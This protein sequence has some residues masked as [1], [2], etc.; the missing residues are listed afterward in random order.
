M[1]IH[2]FVQHANNGD[3]IFDDLIHSQVM[4]VEVGAH[5][6]RKLASF[7]AK[8]RLIGQC[9]QVVFKFIKVPICLLLAPLM[10]RVESDVD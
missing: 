9:L 5:S 8:M 7:P 2:A 1:N 4:G 10:V 6:G 3:A